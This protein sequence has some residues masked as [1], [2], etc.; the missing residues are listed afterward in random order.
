MKQLL[1][2]IL[3]VGIGSGSLPTMGSAD[4]A[5]GEDSSLLDALPLEPDQFPE[6][7]EFIEAEYPREALR[8]GIEG[9]VLLELMITAEGIVD[10]VFVLESLRSDLDTAAATAAAGFVFKP[11]MAE[12]EPVP[13]Y[14]HFAYQF[15]L[16]E[17]VRRIPEAIAL[18]GQVKEKGTRLK[19][20]EAMVVL[21]LPT[22]CSD[23]TLTVPWPLYRERLGELNG[24]YLEEG[25]IV[26]FTDSLG[27]FEFK[28]IPVGTYGISFPNAGYEPFITALILGYNE[29]LEVEY[30]LTRSSYDEYEL[31]V[32]GK[33]EQKEVTRQQL[34][35]TEIERIPGFGGDAIKAVQA[36][37]GVSRASYGS[38][39]L[40]IRGSGEEDT[41]YYLDG[42]D[43]PLLFHYG[44]LKSTYNSQALAS[45]DMYPGG[46]NSRYGGC[47]GG[48]VEIKGRPGAE[49]RWK[50]SFD[51]NLLDATIMAE[52]PINEK[53]TL[54][55]T[56][57]RSYIGTMVKQYLEEDDNV[58]IAVVPY[59]YDYVARADYKIDENSRLFLTV[60][61]AKDRMEII[62]D[63]SAGSDEID[64]AANA[65]SMN[66]YFSRYILGYDKRFNLNVQN[67]LRLS[68]GTDDYHGNY[69]G[70][71]M[72]KFK[73]RNYVLRDELN[74]KL[75]DTFT[76]NIGADAYIV[77]LDYTVHFVEAGKSVQKK[78]FTDLGAYMNAEITPNDKLFLMPGVR[79]DYY[80]ELKEGHLSPRITAKYKLNEKRTLLG[81]AGLYNQSPRPQGQ[82]I[83]PVFGN[84]DLPATTARHLT[85]GTE[86]ELTDR[87]RAKVEG[88]YNTQDNIPYQTDSLD[89]NFLPELKAR[90]YGI[91]VMVRHEQGKRFFGWISYCLTRSE[92]KAPWQP[93]SDIETWDA[94]RW[95]LS[96][97]DQTHHIEAIGSWRLGHNWSVGTRIR[98]V[99]GNPDTA[100]LGYTAGEFVYD[101]DD[102]E[103]EPVSGDYLTD[104]MEPF[105]QIDLRVDKKFIHDNWLMSLYLDVQNVNYKWY[106]S[107][108]FYYYNYDYSERKKIGGIILPTIGIRAEF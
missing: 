40:I 31:V 46:F 68:F 60:F 7:I 98:Y 3:V 80:T 74:V 104:R 105:F 2:I 20:Q 32:Y 102:G 36:L 100:L 56:G 51:V 42:I 33:G 9:D 17:Q 78:T 38:G 15:S 73:T 11:A 8:D 108:E 95:V 90:M 62:E 27:Y 10:S 82:S 4:E 85:L 64:A 91:E 92:R 97:L 106:N 16:R 5:P 83:D 79:Y 53:M 66:S 103:Y 48:V 21:T 39:A 88:Y 89:Y 61:T 6:L 69:L 19:L 94:D 35:M 71:A 28:S 87:I 58:D 14:L 13:V 1:F 54:S 63:E 23:T 72:Y 70:Y 59:Y 43:I 44:G 18:S 101:A 107:P 34:S 99:T 96:A 45:I 77:P 25:N 65:I 12:G 76:Y 49:E 26:T 29:H 67:E 37:P 41:R 55:L 86:W 30:K 93:S 84:P 24:Q 57:R 81:S 47:V 22:V 50:K 52:G 75:N